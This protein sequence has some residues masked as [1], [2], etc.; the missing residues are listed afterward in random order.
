MASKI[1]SKQADAPRTLI[2]WQ[3]VRFTLPAE[4]N[5]TGFSMERDNGYLK[6]DSPGT[7]FVQIKWSSPNV[8]KP[9]T[10]GDWIV[11]LWRLFRP[12]PPGE[13]KIPD[14]RQMLE[15]F[16]KQ[17]E[18]QARK[19]KKPFESKIKPETVEANGERIAHH[20]TWSGQ[21]QG[22]GKIWYCKTCRRVVIAQ[23]VGQK[24]DNLADIA[25]E[26]FGSLC[27]HP[28]QGWATWALYDMVAGVPEDF[29]LKSQKLMSGY[30][31]LEFERRAE[32]IVIERWGLANV[33]RKRFSLEEWLD[34][35]YPTR[36]TRSEK[37]SAI[38]QEHAG[39][40]AHGRVRSPLDWIRA[41]RDALF[42]LRPAT[43][44]SVCVWECEETNKIYG[45]Q[46]WRNVRTK[47]LL[48]EVMARCECH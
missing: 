10:L 15:S 37:Q 22:Q 4:W 48:E 38:V 42:S 34:T 13:E 47:G 20:F 27:D 25:S 43:C 45:I 3:G 18:K 44:Y 14:I 1:Q 26:M 32:R 39:W 41:M 2:G 24:K 23:V 6:V 9:I 33:V 30:L 46:V 5:I 12:A 21:G 36:S 31:K 40:I 17:T 29:S 19:E 16:L 28:Q 11:R 35:T 8:R 7:M